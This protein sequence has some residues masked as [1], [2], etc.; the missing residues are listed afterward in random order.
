V[1][2]RGKERNLTG[3]NKR[4][5]EENKPKFLAGVT[6]WIKANPERRL[7]YRQNRRAAG[8]LLPADVEEIAKAQKFKCAA[9]RTDLKKSGQHIDHIRPIAMGGTSARSNIQLLCPTC[10][11]RKGAKDPITFMQSVG[12]LL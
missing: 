9:C 10:N 1:L 8:R 11:R 4:Y 6:A 12:R 5:Y 7:V 3:Y 2:R